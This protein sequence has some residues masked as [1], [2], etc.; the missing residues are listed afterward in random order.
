[1]KI[2]GQIYELLNIA[3]LILTSIPPGIIGACN[4]SLFAK[5]SNNMII[6]SKMMQFVLRWNEEC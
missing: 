5:I 6:K 4:R 2:A 3:D 1:M